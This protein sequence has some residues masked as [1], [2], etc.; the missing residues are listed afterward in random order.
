MRERERTDT[1]LVET[2]VEDNDAFAHW[3][4]DSLGSGLI[5]IDAEERV[6]LL[7]GEA[8]RILRAEHPASKALEEPAGGR[9]GLNP[10][11]VTNPGFGNACGRA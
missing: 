6:A 4:V 11:S 5:A 2:R 7:N 1:R 9:P 10:C 8:R 3:W